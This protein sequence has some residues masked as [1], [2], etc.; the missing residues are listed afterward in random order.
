MIH[1]NYR[2][3]TGTPSF[4]FQSSQCN[5]LISSVDGARISAIKPGFDA[6]YVHTHRENKSENDRKP[7]TERKS[8]RQTDTGTGVT[9][10]ERKERKTKEAQTNGKPRSKSARILGRK[11]TREAGESDDKESETCKRREIWGD[12]ENKDAGREWW[13]AIGRNS[14]IEKGNRETELGKG[15]L[16]A[17]RPATFNFH[18]TLIRFPPLPVRLMWPKR[19]MKVPASARE[20]GKCKA[21]HRGHGDG[22]ESVEGGEKDDDGRRKE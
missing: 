10:T 8:K 6:Q 22:G 19:D 15:R 4:T 3:A 2:H 18:S 11:K 21:R 1:T 12:K 13:Q 5:G 7:R 14:E 9:E 17:H 16:T 20:V